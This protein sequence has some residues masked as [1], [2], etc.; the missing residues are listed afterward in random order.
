[1]N[2][3]ET[4]QKNPAS[5]VELTR[6]EMGNLFGVSIETIKRRT[7][8]GTLKPNARNARVLRYGENDVQAMIQLGYRMSDEPAQTY[9]FKADSLEP[10]K[11]LVQSPAG[12]EDRHRALRKMLDEHR[13]DL[14]SKYI[15]ARWVATLVLN[16]E[17]D[18]T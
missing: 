2:P 14:I 9:G 13:D 11:T 17:W 18:P 3:P 1:M 7:E 12:N 6:K 8:D 16:D 15:I 5:R 4:T 10:V